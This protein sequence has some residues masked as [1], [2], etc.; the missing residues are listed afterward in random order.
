MG[1]IDRSQVAFFRTDV[2][3]SQHRPADGKANAWTPR[4]TAAMR[5]KRHTSDA[6]RRC[7]PPVLGGVRLIAL[8]SSFHEEQAWSFGLLALTHQMIHSTPGCHIHRFPSP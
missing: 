3:S 4:A 7:V 5:K 2:P 8:A 6:R 1:P